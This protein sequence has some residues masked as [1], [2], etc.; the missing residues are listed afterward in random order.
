M[1][2]FLGPPCICENTAGGDGGG[3]TDG[4][5]RKAGQRRGGLDAS[6]VVVARQ[7]TQEDHSGRSQAPA[8]LLAVRKFT[9]LSRVTA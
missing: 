2:N 4:D 7:T 9:P 1:H 5:G 3:R 8:R 6:C